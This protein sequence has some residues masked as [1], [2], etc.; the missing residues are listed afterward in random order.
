MLLGVVTKI[1]MR[2]ISNSSQTEGEPTH[3]KRGL[4]ARASSGEQRHPRMLSKTEGDA[5][6]DEDEVW[7]MI[8]EF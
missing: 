5:E 3:G 6:L 7:I 2:P 1:C 8:Q 4:P